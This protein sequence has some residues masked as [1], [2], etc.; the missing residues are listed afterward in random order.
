[1]KIRNLRG[2]TGSVDLNQ[3]EGWYLIFLIPPGSVFFK[4]EK[5]NVKENPR[6][7]YIWKIKD[8]PDPKT[9]KIKDPPMVS[10]LLKILGN[11]YE[12]PCKHLRP[13]DVSNR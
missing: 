7:Q 4:G 2:N 9:W 3:C 10:G 6:I 12:S 11:H 1:M 13:F 5:V 8:P